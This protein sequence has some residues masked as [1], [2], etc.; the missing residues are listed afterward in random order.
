M[1]F[2]CTECNSQ[3]IIVFFVKMNIMAITEGSP[4][5]SQ[6]DYYDQSYSARNDYDS[7]FNIAFSLRGNYE[8]CGPLFNSDLRFIA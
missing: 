8:L 1:L 3:F 5:T 4:K 2:T 6:N 7:H